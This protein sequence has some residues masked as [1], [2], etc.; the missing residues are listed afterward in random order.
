MS[1]EHRSP[2]RLLRG[3][4]GGMSLLCAA[5][6]PA[7]AAEITLLSSVGVT[8]VLEELLPQFE[9]ATGHKVVAHLGTAAATKKAIDGGAAFDVAIL[10][11]GLVDDLIKEGKAVAGTNKIVARSGLG[12]AVR[13]G[14]PKPDIASDEAFTRVPRAA[15]SIGYTDPSL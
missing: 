10:T 15:S 13:E 8:A 12:A 1:A 6:L 2:R 7:A 9:R 4:V 5:G 11:P 3:A 14:A